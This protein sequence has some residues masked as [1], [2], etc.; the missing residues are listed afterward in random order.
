MAQEIKA[1]QKYS[2]DKFTMFLAGAI[3]MGEAEDWQK[4]VVQELSSLDITILNPRRDNWDPSW[5]Q[6]KDN[7]T[8]LEQV[9]WEQDGIEDSDLVLVVFTKDCKAPITLLELGMCLDKSN[10]RVCCPEGYYRK[11]NVDIVCSRADI[12]V[13]EDL[14]TMLSGVKEFVKERIAWLDYI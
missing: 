10:V 8:F 11:G 4:K 7:P 6:S 13:Y 3:D 2:N 12:P 5:K 1:P 9:N 14:D